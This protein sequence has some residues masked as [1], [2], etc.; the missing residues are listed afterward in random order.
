[1]RKDYI[2]QK[3]DFVIVKSNINLH[4]GQE[5]LRLEILRNPVRYTTINLSRQWGKSVFGRELLN[6]CAISYHDYEKEVLKPRF[7]TKKGECQI[8]WTSPTIQQAKKV[9][10]EVKQAWKPILYYSNA[11]DRLLILKNGTQVQFFGVD[12][13]DNIRGEG[14]NYMICDEFAFYKEGVFDTVLRPMLLTQGKMVFLISTPNGMNEFYKYH[15]RGLSAEFPQY[16]YVTGTYPE[17]PFYDINEIEDARKTL[18]LPIF[19]QEY[20]A[21]FVGGGANVFGNFERLMIINNWSDPI[22]TMEYYAGTDLAKQKD[23]TVTTTIDQNHKVANILRL[24]QMD[25]NHIMDAV[26]NDFKR[27]N[28]YALMEIN[29]IGDAVFDI[30]RQKF[31]QVQPFATTNQSKQMII[32]NLITA[33]NIGSI[34]L[35]SKELFPPLHEEMNM[36]TFDYSPEKRQI[37]YKA[38]EGFHDDTIISLA[39]ANMQYRRFNGINS[40]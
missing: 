14:I 27:Y 31:D 6:F 9:Y 21:K 36:F 8:I 7:L 16:K 32:Q 15:Q 4:P 30:V 13:P 24:R 35:P 10:K 40:E 26:I 3:L 29:N 25:W 18:P 22:S 34:K 23:W 39:L 38:R 1:M 11:S 28:P 33:C 17:N 2:Q 19:E 37:V 5:R 20:L 12:K